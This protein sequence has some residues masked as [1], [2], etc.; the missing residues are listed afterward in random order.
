MFKLV[1]NRNEKG[2]DQNKVI[3]NAVIESIKENPKVVALDA[4]LGTCS[5]FANIAKEYPN[6]YIECGI[7]E[8]NMVGVAA[9]M[10]V[11][12][13]TPIVHSFAPF[14]ARRDFDQLFL[15]GAYAHNTINVYGSDPG[16]AVAANGGT[17]TSWEDIAI[18]RTIPNSIVVDVCDETQAANVTKQ[19]LKLDGIHYIRSTRKPLRK[20]YTPDST[21]EIGKGNVVREGNDLLIIT[22]GEML[23]DAL[24]AAEELQNQGISCEVIDM[25]TIK[26]LD[27]ELVRKE[28]KGKKAVLTIE[29][30]SVYGGLGSAVNDVLVN[31]EDR[32]HVKNMGVKDE[33]GQVGTVDYLKKA[34]HLTKEDIIEQAKLITK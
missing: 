15:S 14:A 8:A 6:N 12:G 26:P 7:A 32:V 17:H 23:T 22:A 10:S 30:A 2:L 9:G 5:G 13:Y 21:F 1:E 19:L 28:V 31:C 24:D 18:M 25:F 16:F 20:V 11:L 33:F 4:D 27:E 29:N 3:T 34:F